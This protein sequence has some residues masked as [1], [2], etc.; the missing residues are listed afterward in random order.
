M[1]VGQILIVFGTMRKGGS[2][3]LLKFLKAISFISIL[4]AA[5]FLA[6]VLLP[7]KEVNEIVQYKYIEDGSLGQ[8]YHA[9]FI[10]TETHLNRKFYEK[11]N[12]GDYVRLRI[13]PVFKDVE[14]VTSIG[15]KNIL[16]ERPNDD[17]YWKIFMSVFFLIPAFIFR[18]K[19]IGK[20]AC[21]KLN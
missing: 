10:N 13:S 9:K 19:D 16:G 3:A 6:D 7:D 5:I 2:N 15:N 11:L 17:F 14:R 4:M 1:V 18:F 21:L 20:I 12:D 8:E